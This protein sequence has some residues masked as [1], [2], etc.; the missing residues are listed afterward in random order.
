MATKKEELVVHDPGTDVALSNDVLAEMEAMAAAAKKE[1]DLQEDVRLPSLKLIQATT[2]ETGGGHA[3]QILDTMSGEVYDS[4]EIVP[5]SMF[6][7]RAF[8]SGNIGDPPSCSSPNALDGYGDE[9]DQLKQGG[10]VGPS[11]GGSCQ[12]CPHSK[13]QTGGRCQLR[14]NYLGLVIGDDIG[15]DLPRGIML[16]GT[17]AK[18]ANRLNSLLISQKFPWS[19]VVELSSAQEKNERGVYKIWAIKK[20]RP[21]TN[22]E[23]L[24]SFQMSKQVAQSRSVTIEGADERAT[25]ATAAATSSDDVPF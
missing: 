15:N 21:A 7:S 19:N 12:A 9:A 4:V 10:I 17:S 24:A 20:G 13:W 23:M 18:V 6:K 1:I 25:A 5:V 16:H 22:V 11:G 3:G 2:Q 8:F 14:Y